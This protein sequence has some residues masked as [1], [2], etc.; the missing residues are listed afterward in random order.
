MDMSSLAEQ[1]LGDDWP[2][3]VLI[4][5]TSGG[6]PEVSVFECRNFDG[7]RAL[8][9]FAKLLTSRMSRIS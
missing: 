9:W 2:F 7:D 5:R 3:G 1:C 8:P 6:R 4:I